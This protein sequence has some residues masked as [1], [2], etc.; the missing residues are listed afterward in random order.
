MLYFKGNKILVIDSLGLIP[1]N[2][3][4]DILILTQSPKVNL[5]RILMS[6][7]PKQ[8]VFDGSNYKSYVKH[9]EATCKKRKIP[10]HNTNEKGFYSY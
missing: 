6:F 10:F 9:W 1:L 3:K 8:V 2:L 7:N 4:P 5:D